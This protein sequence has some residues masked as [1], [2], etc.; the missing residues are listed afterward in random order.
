MLLNGRSASR[1]CTYLKADKD[2]PKDLLQVALHVGLDV[3]NDGGPHKVAL[4]KAG[5]F[6]SPPVQHDACA[7]HD[8]SCSG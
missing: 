1:A 6:D 5:H 4:L 3:G 8:F 2:G 7:L